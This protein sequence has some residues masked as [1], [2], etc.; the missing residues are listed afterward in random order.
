MKALLVRVTT[1]LRSVFESI[2]WKLKPSRRCWWVW[3]H[4][5]GQIW[6]ESVSI[7]RS[8]GNNGW[9][10][11]MTTG[12]FEEHMLKIEGLLMSTTRLR[13][14]LMSIYRNFDL[15]RLSWWGW[16]RDYGQFSR[17]YVENWSHQGSGV[18]G[19][20]V[21]TASFW[22]HMLKIEAIKDLLVRV[23]TWLRPNL[24]RVY[25]TLKVSRQCW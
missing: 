17:A 5:Y 24:K 13:T 10:D 23:T 16:L 2:C 8:Q 22:Q 25:W 21:T 19:D 7:L 11:Y 9:L 18:E 14:V 15:W 20:Y 3:L 1:W 4:D 6:S 12:S